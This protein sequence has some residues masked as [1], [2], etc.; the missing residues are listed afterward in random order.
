M[1]MLRSG[2]L[3][4]LLLPLG[5]LAPAGAEESA[6]PAT[7]GVLPPIIRRFAA[8][9]DSLRTFYSRSLS[10]LRLERLTRFLDRWDAALAGLPYEGLGVDDRVDYVLLRNH[11]QRRR[12]ELALQQ[13]RNGEMLPLLGHATQLLELD[14]A[15]WRPSEAPDGRRMAGALVEVRK[16]LAAGRALVEKVHAGA[17]DLPADAPRLT[18]VIA[19]R[20]SKALDALAALLKDWY[21]FHDGF[22]PSFAWW[23][24]RPYDKLRKDIGEYATFLRT[25]VA[26]AER[27]DG[28]VAPLIGDPI[29]RAALL[30]ALAREMIPYTP[31]QLLALAER[32]FAWCEAEGA[33]A[34]KAI[35][36]DN[37]QQGLAHVKALHEKPGGQAAM[38]A[39]Q[40]QEAID[41]LE[42]R[43]LLT[44]PPLAKE[45]WR[46]RMIG[47]RAQKTYPFA[48]YWEQSMFVAYAMAD[49]DHASKLMSMRGNNEHFS[50]IVTPHEL[51]PGHHLQLFQ[52][53]RHRAYRARFRT[54]FLV[55][56][57]ALHWEMLLWDLGWARDAPD[58]IG[59]LFWRMH[60]CARIIITL[61][62]HLGQMST[63]EMIEFLVQRVGHETDSA[64]S[65]V[66]RYIAGAY[67]P[68]YQCA[69]MVGGL[70][71]RALHHELVGNG[72][73]SNRQF[74]DAVLRENS[75]PIELIRAALTRTKLP[76][77]HTGSWAW[78][79]KVTPAGGS[80]PR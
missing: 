17:K 12:D 10:E 49:M 46:L 33:K 25:K 21:A 52:A 1:H 58:R 48:Y 31:E 44:L 32:E 78:Q 69:Y 63:A 30:R 35:G 6:A 45:T 2:L 42:S 54:P 36:L 80:R 40:A 3:V 11:L 14:R 73:M 60:R 8:D 20:A 55:E 57:W 64:T 76:R 5:T 19:F 74:H 62:F 39:K 22:D 13:A 67:G 71:M 70:Q 34:A 68:L 43:E 41:F 51:I 65:E 7:D 59:M 18:P 27:D 37:W 28:G 61:R 53:A 4:I 29:G 23:V 77:D 38:V 66:R 56:G 75:I 72:R 50:R 9:E 79:G 24:K 15:R 26:G 47:K 16:D